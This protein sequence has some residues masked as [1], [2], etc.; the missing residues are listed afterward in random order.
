MKRSPSIHPI[1]ILGIGILAVSTASIFIRF[2]QEYAGS[3][4]I[5]FYRLAIATIFLAPFVLVRHQYELKC[6]N[7]RQLLLALGAGLFLALHFATWITSLEYTSVASSVVLVSTVPLWVAL[8]APFT[9]K[10][11][12][13]RWLILGLILALIGGIIVGLSDS[14]HIVGSTLAC[15]SP[16]SFIQRDAFIGDIL[17]LMGA[18]MAAGYIIVGRN[19]RSTIS[20][21][22]YVFIVYG[23]GA[24]VL[25][26]FVLIRSEPLLGYSTQAYICFLFL[27]LIPQLL[28][29]SS[30]NWALGYLSAVFVSISLLGEPIGS[31]ILAYFILNESPGIFKIF[32]AILILTGIYLA[33]I[34][35][36]KQSSETS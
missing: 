27:A 12:L 14:C 31:T 13:T 11:P 18:I 30:F 10:E 28:G 2:A 32:G 23:I 16:K 20:L 15:P 21:S 29:H 17:A 6:L 36:I 34:G 26:I 22:S 24:L 25:L 7:R 1:I 3:L 8:L 9:L 35:E 33:S 5:S 19:L 4:V